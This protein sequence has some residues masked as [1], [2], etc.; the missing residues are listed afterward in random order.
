MYYARLQVLEKVIWIGSE[1][2][3]I[4]SEGGGELIREKEQVEDGL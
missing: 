4:P 2:K 1:L 3:V